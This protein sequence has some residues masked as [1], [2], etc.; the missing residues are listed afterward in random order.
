MTVA[1]ATAGL[2]GQVARWAVRRMGPAGLAGNSFGCAICAAVWFGAGTRLGMLAGGVA[3]CASRLL[4][5]L[6][7]QA[8]ARDERGSA[9]DLARR[10]GARDGS[11][12][13]LDLAWR[14]GARDESGA[15]P[16][17]AAEGS[18][19]ATGG[20]V[21]AEFAVYAGLAAGAPAAQSPQIWALASGAM[22]LLALRQLAGLCRALTAAGAPEQPRPGADPSGADPRGEDPPG[23][24]RLGRDRLGGDRLGGD[25]LGGD[26][27][28]GDRLGGDRLGGWLVAGRWLA[29]LPAGVRAVLISVTALAWGPRVA[30]TALVGAGAVVVL[31]GLV[32]YARQPAA[33]AGSPSRP[34]G[35]ISEP[36][37]ELTGSVSDLPAISPRPGPG[38]P[39]LL[40]GSDSELPAVPPGSISGISAIPLGPAPELPAARF[41]SAVLA[42]SISGPPSVLPGS[43]S[44][45]AAAPAGSVTELPGVAAG[46]PS[47]LAVCRDDGVIARWGGRL[48]RGLLQPL[49]PAIAG[50]AATSLLAGVGMRGLPMEVVLAPVAALLLAAAGAGHPHGGR[51]DWLV[52]PIILAGQY[53]Y[54]TALGLAARVPGPLVFALV[55]LIAMSQLKTARRAGEQRGP[56]QQRP[57]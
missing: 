32:R 2:P 33:E 34:A 27:L 19:L 17:G 57:A 11:G 43:V 54:L 52:P 16:G 51:L 13:A 42:G 5:H 49:P 40:P 29:A 20:P 25:R 44:E 26:R 8:A 21:T 10:A 22:I 15:A 3:L 35:S 6:A 46:S 47:R 45:L 30:L 55:T 7:R 31:A 12:S 18:W 48:A 24:D 9:L 28:G 36:P 1:M 56:A 50:L 23:A 14:A 38:A 4:L 39:T 37:I 41:G 53:V